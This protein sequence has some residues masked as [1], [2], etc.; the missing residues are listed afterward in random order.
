V[1]WISLATLVTA[2]VLLALFWGDVPGRWAIHW[3]LGGQPDGWA[4]KSMPAAL[5]PLI[6]G[7]FVWLFIE[8]TAIWIGTSGA[9]A[10]SGFPPEML[11]VQAAV[12][13]AAGLA[14][15]L[16]TGG[17]TLALPF[18]HPRSSVPILIAAF[19]DIGLCIGIAMV[20]ASRRTRRL[21]ESGVAIP[22]GYHGAVYRNPRDERLWV[23]KTLGIGW[24][25]NF[26]HRLAW[27]VM[28]ALVAAPLAMVLLV[29]LAAR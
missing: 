13:R 3:G 15:A 21:R 17:L 6:I 19:A 5:A 14:V 8:V 16:L 23:P 27:P 22:D 9:R 10:A 4:T 28:I 12:V 7:L 11:A 24:T 18:L 2:G 20:W 29:A 26:A 25:I 1:R